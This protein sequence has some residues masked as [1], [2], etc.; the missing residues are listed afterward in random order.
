MAADANQ[1]MPR[2]FASLFPTHRTKMPGLTAYSSNNAES[3]DRHGGATSSVRNPVAAATID[4]ASRTGNAC[5]TSAGRSCALVA[6]LQ[7][8]GDTAHKNYSCGMEPILSQAEARE[9][10]CGYARHER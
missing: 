3:D 7:A 5:V 2:K 9:S 1:G 6:R 8:I 10:L 4:K